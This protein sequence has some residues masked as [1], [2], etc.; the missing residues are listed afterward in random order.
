MNRVIATLLLAMG[1]V[2][3]TPAASDYIPG[4]LLVKFKPG[5]E[6]TA[7]LST[8]SALIKTIPGINVSHVKLPKG[9]TVEQGVNLFKNRSDVV[10]VSPNYVV[11]TFLTPNDPRYAQQWHLPKIQAPEAW[12]LYTGSPTVTI[13]IVD[14]GIDLDHEDLAAKI[15]PGKDFVNN[16]DIADDDNGHGTHCAGIAAGI[17]NNNIGIAGLAWQ[18]KL[19]PVKVLA[20]NGFGSLDWLAQ[21]VIFAA[22]NGAQIISMSLGSFG[23]SQTVRDA[24]VYAID[25]GSI[26]IAAAGNHG[27]TQKAYPAAYP[28]VVAVANTMQ[29]DQRNP[30]SAYGDWVE[31]A[32]PGTDIMSTFPGNA[33]G[34]ATGTSMACPLVAGLAG[35]IKS[36]APNMTVEQLKN[37]IFNNCDP[38]GDFV[39]YGRINAFKSYPITNIGGDYTSLP[40]SYR[41]IE[42]S[43]PT[44]DAT[45]LHFADGRVVSFAPAT[46]NRLG[47]SAA[48]EANVPLA[49]ESDRILSMDVAFDVSARK[50]LSVGAYLWN[51]QT[52]S[53]DYIKAVPLKDGFTTGIVKVNAPYGK[54]IDSTGN[55]KVVLRVINPQTTNA[56]PARFTMQVDR[57]IITGR[58]QQND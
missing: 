6:K 20:G 26:V 51:F 45:A 58:A 48:I 12:D 44:G 54:Y 19:M 28:E 2:A 42:G 36:A 3:S 4:E 18:C 5:T 14:S 39:V 16:D 34:T 38:V 17:A 52:N 10:H 13:A 8:R 49:V 55:A 9:M 21:G 41:I 15:V 37:Q 46:V 40:N 43:N 47:L 25:K 22:D 33:Y 1:V 27:T 50:G 30:G 7:V 24:M 32:A 57:L 35:L 31:V 53:Y 11:R 23:D 29:N 56:M